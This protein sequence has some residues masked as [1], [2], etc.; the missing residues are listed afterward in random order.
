MGQAAGWIMMKC[1]TVIDTETNTDGEV[2][3]TL[4]CDKEFGKLS[5]LTKHKL[6]AHDIRPT[7]LYASLDKDELKELGVVM[8]ALKDIHD[9]AL[10][11]SRVRLYCITDLEDEIERLQ[12]LVDRLWK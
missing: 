11:G 2:I 1:D 8:V 5:Q 4:K 7:G 12:K 10:S 6:V 3:D 9:A